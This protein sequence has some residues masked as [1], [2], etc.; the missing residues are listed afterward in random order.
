[1]APIVGVGAGFK[2]RFLSP[3]M[4]PKVD[5]VATAGG[6]SF[7]FDRSDLVLFWQR[8]RVC[9]LGLVILAAVVLSFDWGAFTLRHLTDWR[10]FAFL[11][12][13]G[14][15]AGMLVDACLRIRRRNTKVL[16]LVF[17][18]VT[19]IAVGLVLLG[20]DTRA[21]IAPFLYA[22]VT[23]AIVLPAGQ[24][25]CMWCCDALLATLVVVSPPFTRWLGAPPTGARLSTA[26]W[27]ATAL[28]TALT[29]AEVLVLIGAL[30]RFALA[31]QAGLAG[32]A[33]RKDE[34][35]AGVSH[36]LR[37]PLTCV[38]GFGQLIEHDWADQ[39]PPAVGVM[40]GELNQQAD[41]MAAMVDNLVIRAQDQ[42]GDIT[43]STEAIDLRDIASG[44]I[45][46]QAWLY[47]DKQIRLTG[48]RDLMAWADPTRTRQVIRNLISNAVQHGGDHIDVSTGNGEGATL[49]V[50]DDGPGPV[51]CGGSLHLEPFEKTSAA[52]GMPSLGL[53]L[54]TSLRLAQL[55]GGDLTHQHTLGVSTFTLT[56]PLSPR[57][58][59]ATTPEIAWP[60]PPAVSSPAPAPVPARVG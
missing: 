46:S 60:P 55:M 34:F 29:L 26:V 2:G 36:A 13:A 33:R 12:V 25:L 41:V 28:F 52:F 42:A 3:W 7:P 6:G 43:L 47:P 40:L 39:L 18:D 38:V 9:L 19:A 22:A 21:L 51:T 35:L 8:V 32:Q 24:A 58:P 49:T 16:L 53:G 57:L 30:R 14:V 59:R 20:L 31:R 1:M 10:G 17:V 44:V 54:P 5:E 48:S 56:L 45:R 27:V 23:A 4:L 11:A 15:G 50:T 37:T